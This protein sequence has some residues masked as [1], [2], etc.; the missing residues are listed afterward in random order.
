MSKPEFVTDEEIA[1][2][3]RRIDAEISDTILDVASLRQNTAA[4]EVM[5]AGL[6]LTTELEKL[7]CNETLAFQFQYTFGQDSF[8]REPWELAQEMLNSYMNNTYTISEN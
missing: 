4:R 6:W 5:R 1:E 7:G 3:D 2:L 8:G